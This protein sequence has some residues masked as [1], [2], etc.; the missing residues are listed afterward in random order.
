MIA[1]AAVVIGMLIGAGI[2]AAHADTEVPVSRRPLADV[3]LR[4]G[5]WN[6][7]EASPFAD[8]VVAQ[9]GVDEYINRVYVR[10]GGVPVALYVGYYASQRQGDTIHS[11][12]N[13]LP[14]AGWQSVEGG[15]IPLQ[16]AARER[17]V[18][19]NRYTVQKGL[20]RQ[21]VL[22]WYQG[23]GRITASEYA[24]KAWLMLDAARLH[25]TN[26]GLVRVIAPVTTDTVGAT[27][28]ATAFVAALL[29]HLSVHLP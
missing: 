14:G 1:R 25:R 11:P 24:A 29:P 5:D 2:Y 28:N 21:V 13:C 19:V 18:Y 6:G 3:P 8:D 17:D 20:D 16:P 10:Q 12:R 23:R 27:A 22:Y 7:R 9:L 4:I 15:T 26:G